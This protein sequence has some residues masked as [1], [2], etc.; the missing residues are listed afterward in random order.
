M[1]TEN[2]KI[3]GFL[4]PPFREGDGW[5]S[6]KDAAEDVCFQGRRVSLFRGA[7]PSGEAGTILPR[8]DILDRVGD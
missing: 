6:H 3:S 7:R 2:G 1:I 4:R 5:V 8:R